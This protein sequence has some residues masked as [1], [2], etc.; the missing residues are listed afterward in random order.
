MVFGRIVNAMATTCLTPVA[1]MLANRGGES[2]GND[3][4]DGIDTWINKRDYDK[5]W[6]NYDDWLAPPDKT[7]ADG[8]IKSGVIIAA[9]A[10]GAMLSTTAAYFLLP[11]SWK[12]GKLPFFLGTI[13]PYCGVFIYIVAVVTPGS[14]QFRSMVVVLSRVTLALGYG[15]Q[16]CI[17]RQIAR[18]DS[19]K[20]RGNLMLWN[21]T[22][23]IVG[24]AS[25]PALVGLALR[26]FTR[27]TVEQTPPSEAAGT[28]G[29]S[30]SGASLEATT[31]S[32]AA[33]KASGM[34]HALASRALSVLTD[35]RSYGEEVQQQMALSDVAVLEEA[36]AHPYVS[37]AGETAAQIQEEEN[38]T[39]KLLVPAVLLLIVVTLNLMAVIFGDMDEPFFAD[40]DGGKGASEDSDAY[41]A[42]IAKLKA[43]GA[44]TES[45]PLT[46]RDSKKGAGG[47][48]DA[49]G[50][51]EEG[52]SGGGGANEEEEDDGEEAEVPEEEEAEPTPMPA[53]PPPIWVARAVQI[54]CIS[55]TF[56][57]VFLRYSYES[58]MVVVYSQTYQFTDGVAGMIAG[59]SAFFALIAVFLW[60]RV[61][62]T[63]T[64]LAKSDAHT[65]H[66]IMV[67]SEI[68]GFSCALV[69]MITPMIRHSLGRHWG[70]FFT[71]LTAVFFYPSQVLG[72]SIANSYPLDYAVPTSPW[73]NRNAMLVQQELIMPVGNG[74]GMLLGRVLTGTNSKSYLTNLGVSFACVMLLQAI[75][76]SVGW[77]PQRTKRVW[78]RMCAAIGRRP[79]APASIP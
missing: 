9:V 28:A 77:D 68:C 60:A 61:R 35:L 70:I 18:V 65:A 56:T 62:S 53:A 72:A 46:A 67:V 47:A 44:P 17:K 19:S 41:K 29:T 30:S 23:D 6:Y 73:L 51:A 79:A 2:P 21:N 38:T 71:L 40:E 8:L 4:K 50:R 1:Y 7:A 16:F 64:S 37:A 58:A 24:M 52:K 3:G 59:G 45:T 78:N 26:L 11:N 15:L 49:G 5:D 25:G 57:R 22:F 55:Y 20:R 14:P 43:R 34:V 13:F 63:S 54:T 66:I 32:A 27:D 10:V 48:A 74:L 12:D 31:A 39:N 76:V 69:M 42:K 36:G 33:A 75:I